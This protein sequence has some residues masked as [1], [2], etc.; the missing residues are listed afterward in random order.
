VVGDSKNV[1]RHMVLGTNPLDSR[2]ASILIP[3]N[4]N[5]IV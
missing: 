4:Y 2:L 1:I 3:T 5:V